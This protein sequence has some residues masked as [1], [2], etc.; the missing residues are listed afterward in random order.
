MLGQVQRRWQHVTLDFEAEERNVLF[1]STLQQI[2]LKK[3][4][5]R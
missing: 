5:R 3:G 1:D 4:P 2:N